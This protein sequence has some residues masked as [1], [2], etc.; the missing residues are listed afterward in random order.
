[1]L[2]AYWLAGWLAGWLP[3][4]PFSRSLTN[5]LQ[6]HLKGWRIGGNVR[7]IRNTYIY[8]VQIAC[9]SIKMSA[10]AAAAAARPVHNACAGLYSHNTIVRAKIEATT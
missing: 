1:M 8:I 10:A 5:T 2:A 3:L 4:I 7:I 9:Q 6:T